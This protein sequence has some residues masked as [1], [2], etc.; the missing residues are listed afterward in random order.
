M[1]G[2]TNLYT[3]LAKTWRDKE[4]DVWQD[5]ETDNNNHKKRLD[6]IREVVSMFSGRSVLD[7]GC[8]AG[9]TT[10]YISQHADVVGIERKVLYHSMA[11]ELRNA[12]VSKGMNKHNIDIIKTDFLGFMESGNFDKYGIDAIFASR[13]V[14]HL[15]HKELDILLGDVLFRCKTVVITT[16]RFKSPPRSG[17]YL[18]D[19]ED[20]I[21]RLVNM[22]FSVEPVIEVPDENPID[23]LI[24]ASK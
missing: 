8:N 1:D 22:G 5:P 9:L 3:E 6:K 7:I 11:M 17:S 21:R 23:F 13:I 24:R 12:I 16:R 18:Y 20:I 4:M 19:M 15:S 14:H 10:A 2:I